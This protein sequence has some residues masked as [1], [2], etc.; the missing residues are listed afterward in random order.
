MKNSATAAIVKMKTYRRE[1]TTNSLREVLCEG[2]VVFFK[3]VIHVKRAK[4]KEE[5]D[6]DRHWANKEPRAGTD[7]F[8]A[9]SMCSSILALG[10]I[11]CFS[12]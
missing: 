8:A 9:Q 4:T 2:E 5:V 3:Q 11:Y 7:V 12:F 1:S 6:T 10:A